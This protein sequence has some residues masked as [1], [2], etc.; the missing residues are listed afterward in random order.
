[1]SEVLFLRCDA[2][3]AM[4]A[5]G[6][7][8]EAL[9]RAGRTEAEARRA[10]RRLTEGLKAAAAAF[11]GGPPKAM[12]CLRGQGEAMEFELLADAGQAPQAL[13]AA[14]CGDGAPLWSRV[15]RRA[16]CDGALRLSM[17]AQG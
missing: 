13:A 10:A 16:P 14:P 12:L 4:D 1:M 17:A 5:G 7:A 3:G 11:A 9:R 8:A 15:E 2:G 6:W